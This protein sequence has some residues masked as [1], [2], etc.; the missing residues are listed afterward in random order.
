MAEEIK[1]KGMKIEITL[2]DQQ[3]IEIVKN[4]PKETRDEIIEKYI[5]LG[6]MIV[7]YASISA[8]KETVENFFAPFRSD[9]EM[10][11]EQLKLIVPT[12]ATPA[13]KGA[14]TVENIF[15][16]FE[17]HFMDDSF[18]DVSV[19]G[20]FSDI[21][22]TTSET[23]TEV[24]IE[25]KDYSGKVPTTEV[26][27]FW[28]DMERRDGRYGIFIS[29]RSGI[30]KISGSIKLETRM[31]RT[32][33]FVVDNE[34][35]WS[36]HLFA[37]YV[38]K[39]IIEL[40]ALKKKELKGEELTKVI[41]RINRYLIEIRKDTKIIEEIQD[42]ADKLKTTCT[43]KLQKLIDL[44]NT[45]ERK[46]NEKI[47]DAFQEI[48]KAEIKP[49]E[50]KHIVPV[51]DTTLTPTEEEL[52]ESLR[53]WR[54]NQATKEGLAPYMIAHNSWLK[55]MAKMCVKTKGDLLHVKGFGEKRAE[56]YGDDILKVV[57][58]F[59]ATRKSRYEDE[60]LK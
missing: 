49:D 14:V 52:Y 37:Y 40:E 27:K 47:T 17:E 23:K 31:N 33:I 32:A 45:Y 3:A 19:I 39:K 56:K 30:T 12:I 7:S 57:E 50:T 48:E 58:S 9:I 1:N 16:S 15:R 53:R 20:K 43:N 18:E 22:A 13:F 42:I 26:E 11:R 36:G 25:L 28:R 59:S 34:L 8:S 10:I 55:Q 41:S 21:K 46:L 29:M 4:L 38:I 2:R 6:N 44:A 60:S 51:E 24:L 35:N 5:I 54:N